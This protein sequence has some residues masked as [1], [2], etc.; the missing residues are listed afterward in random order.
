MSNQRKVGYNVKPLGSL[1][2][3][4]RKKR[5]WTQARLAAE[6]GFDRTHIS[7]VENGKPITRDDLQLLAEALDS[8]VLTLLAMGTTTEP[9]LFDRVRLD[10]YITLSKAKQEYREAAEAIEQVLAFAHNLTDWTSCS[11]TEKEAIDHMLGQVGDC[12]HVSANVDLAAHE[13]GCDIQKRNR[14]NRQKYVERGYISKKGGGV[15]AR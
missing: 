5:G 2:R 9:L 14:I 13:F 3:N 15:V 1:V 10:F 7:K 8:M 12:H 6:V 4:E 11:E